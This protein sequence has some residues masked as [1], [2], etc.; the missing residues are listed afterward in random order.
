MIDE[1]YS[2]TMPYTCCDCGRSMRT[3][4]VDGRCYDCLAPVPVRCGS[5]ARVKFLPPDH[6]WDWQDHPGKIPHEVEGY[7]AT[8][9][10][11]KRKAALTRYLRESRRLLQ[12]RRRGY[13]LATDKVLWNELKRG[14]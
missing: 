3:Q 6:S 4:G 11:T 8:C 9:G 5:C 12:E 1:H 10:G 14:D 2:S 7:C 13:G